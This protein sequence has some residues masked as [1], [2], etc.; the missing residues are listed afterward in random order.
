MAYF[1]LLNQEAFAVSLQPLFAS[2]PVHK[3]QQKSKE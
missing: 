3:D 1:A 2:S